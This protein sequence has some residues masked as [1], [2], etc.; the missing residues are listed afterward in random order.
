MDNFFRKSS[1]GLGSSYT[2]VGSYSSPY[3]GLGLSS[4]PGC[5]GCSKGSSSLSSLQLEM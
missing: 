5:G 4:K 3:S 2:G 1:Y